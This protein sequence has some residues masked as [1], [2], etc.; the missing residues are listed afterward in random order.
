FNE[1]GRFPPT[2][3]IRRELGI[4]PHLGW[5]TKQK[6]RDGIPAMLDARLAGVVRCEHE[7][8]SISPLPGGSIGM[9]SNHLQSEFPGMPGSGPGYSGLDLVIGIANLCG[10]GSGRAQ[11]CE[12][13]RDKCRESSEAQSRN[14]QASGTQPAILGRGIQ[15][16]A[17]Y[18]DANFIDQ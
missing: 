9:A 10:R 1:A 8:S 16:E 15:D 7:S 4:A 3:M 6:R 14:S 5:I 12:P 11:L 18:A 13:G 17:R 2:K